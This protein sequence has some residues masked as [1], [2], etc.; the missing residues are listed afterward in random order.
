MLKELLFT[1]Q[2]K[3]LEVEFMNSVQLGSVMTG[4]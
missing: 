1:I 4:N 3:W 2:K